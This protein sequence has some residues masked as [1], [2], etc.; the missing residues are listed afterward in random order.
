MKNALVK[1]ALEVPDSSKKGKTR[2]RSK[3]KGRK[4]ILANKMELVEQ[5][6]GSKT[7]ILDPS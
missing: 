2:G 1:Q 4:S 3:K 5:F 7:I 6:H